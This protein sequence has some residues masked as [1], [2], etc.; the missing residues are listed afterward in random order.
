MTLPEALAIYLY[1]W[2]T[3]MED[4]DEPIVEAA[5]EVI[6][7]EARKAMAA[8]SQGDQP[9]H[10]RMPVTASPDRDCVRNHA[11]RDPTTIRVWRPRLRARWRIKGNP[12]YGPAPAISRAM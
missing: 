9:Q 12:P 11:F 5:V 8:Y 3:D 4:S 10:G 1:V 7:R 2:M 6:E